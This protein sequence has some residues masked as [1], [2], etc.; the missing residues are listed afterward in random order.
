MPKTNDIII[1]ASLED[2]LEA[3][4]VLNHQN[5]SV[6]LTDIAEFLSVSKPSVN[7]AIGTLK[8]A[9]LIKHEVYGEIALTNSGKARAKEVLGRHNLLKNFLKDT[10]GVSSETAESDA[11]RMEHV[12]SHESIDK[13]SEFLK[14]IDKDNK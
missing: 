11:C 12:M 9:G 1:T 6:R 7:R 3:V 4:F 10:L 13:L 14:N 2:Y 5:K 8:D